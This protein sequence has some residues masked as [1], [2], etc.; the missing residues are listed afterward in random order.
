MK[1]VITFGARMVVKWPII[2]VTDQDPSFVQHP[3]FYGSQKEYE[4]QKVARVK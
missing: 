3:T 2:P 4:T 1:N